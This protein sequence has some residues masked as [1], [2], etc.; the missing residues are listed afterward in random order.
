MQWA[1]ASIHS[2]AFCELREKL[3][4]PPSLLTY[5][6]IDL[7]G[8]NMVHNHTY[9]SK[10]HVQSSHPGTILPTIFSQLSVLGY[11]TI[12]GHAYFF[13]GH[14]AS[15]WSALYRFMASFLKS[16]LFNFICAVFACTWHKFNCEQHSLWFSQKSRY[17]LFIDKHS[18]W[19]SICL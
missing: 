10:I 1:C 9:F 5:N 3:G 14:C 13:Y 8:K 16:S 11:N 17:V 7:N 12:L 4:M 18:T 6:D 2:T 15:V 19:N